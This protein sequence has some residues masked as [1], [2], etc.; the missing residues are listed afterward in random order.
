MSKGFYESKIKWTVA[1][2]GLYCFY[3]NIVMSVLFCTQCTCGFNGCTKIV[4]ILCSACENSYVVGVPLIL[5]QWWIQD[6][7]MWGY[8]HPGG[9][10][11]TI[12]QRIPK[13]FMKWKEFGPRGGIQNVTMYIRHCFARGNNGLVHEIL[14]L[15]LWKWHIRLCMKGEKVICSC[16]SGKGGT[17]IGYCVIPPCTQKDIDNLAF[18]HATSMIPCF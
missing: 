13:N 1:D 18:R 10:Q 12:L 8:Q 5:L 15:P 2:P 11:H 16:C 7:L 17:Y 3:R 14:S 6:F 4:W 9:C